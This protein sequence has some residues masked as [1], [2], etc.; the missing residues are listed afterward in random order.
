MPEPFLPYPDV[1]YKTS[2]LAG[3]IEFHAEGRHTVWN[4]DA[5]AANFEKFVQSFRDYETKP[6]AGHVPD[7]TYWLIVDGEFAG[8][9][10]VRHRLNDG[11]WKLGGH[12]GYEIRP[13]FRR[14]G[15]G[16]L[17]ARL[18][19]EKARLLGLRQVLITCDDDNIASTK[20]IETLGGVLE[21]KIHVEG[22]PALI[23]RYW[24]TL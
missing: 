11:L 16:K 13:S 9:I 20:I 19:L 12:I 7:S 21:D 8:R 17:I 10:T 2:F 18:G 4:Y 23:R 15:L 1:V 3:L 22:H 24:V 5:I 14:H 6:T